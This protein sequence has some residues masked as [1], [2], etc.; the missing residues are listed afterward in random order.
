[1]QTDRC[2]RFKYLGDGYERPFF[3]PSTGAAR[4]S[5][6]LS[7]LFHTSIGRTGQLR[8]CPAQESPRSS[9]GDDARARPFRSVAGALGFSWRFP[10]P[11][12]TDAANLWEIPG[13]EG[14]E[15]KATFGMQIRPRGRRGGGAW[16]NDF[17]LSLPFLFLHILRACRWLRHQTSSP[18]FGFLFQDY[19]IDAPVSVGD[20]FS[21]SGGELTVFLTIYVATIIVSHL[22]FLDCCHSH[23]IF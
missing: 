13:Q 4:T 20:G 7:P 3:A 6:T 1:M 17:A 14:E 18:P 10:L 23:W 21:F 9:N 5:E 2:E 22:D 12:T 19:L 16:I 15:G 11:V 8:N